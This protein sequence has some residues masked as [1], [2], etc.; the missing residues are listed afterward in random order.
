MQNMLSLC[1][2]AVALLLVP[3]LGTSDCE[4]GTTCV[5]FQ[6]LTDPL[7]YY[8][9]PEEKA[10]TPDLFPMP[11]CHGVTI[12]EATID[13]LQDALGS[14]R[15]TCVQLAQCYLDRMEQVDGYIKYVLY[16]LSSTCRE[17]APIYSVG[18]QKPFGGGNIS[19]KIWFRRA[20]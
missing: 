19:K 1:I 11:S 3:S 10:E 7:P 2:V 20:P 18:A 13:A 12:E 14:G 4:N 16:L 6:T 17:F 8:F 5:D 15:L 9:P